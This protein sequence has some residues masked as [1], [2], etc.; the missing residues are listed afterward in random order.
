[1]LE[2]MKRWVHDHP[3]PVGVVVLL[4]MLLALAWTVTL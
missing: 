2:Q 1:M 4:F 3:A